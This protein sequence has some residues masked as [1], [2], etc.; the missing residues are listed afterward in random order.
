MD[1]RIYGRRP[2]GASRSVSAGARS[3][4]WPN[5]TTWIVSVSRRWETGEQYGAPRAL[6]ASL[7]PAPPRP[8]MK[9][10]RWK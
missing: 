5:L 1:S 6:R 4:L 9:L 3:A 8:N 2:R 7:G 10:N